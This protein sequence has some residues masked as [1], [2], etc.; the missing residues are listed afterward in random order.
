MKYIIYGF[1]GFGHE[2]AY[3]INHINIDKTNWN[4]SAT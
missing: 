2:I 3:L 1:G 4:I